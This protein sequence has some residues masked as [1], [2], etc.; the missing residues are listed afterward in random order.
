VDNNIIEFVRYP[1]E[2]EGSEGCFKRKP[3]CESSECGWHEYCLGGK[4]LLNCRPYV[5]IIYEGMQREDEDA[6]L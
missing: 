6:D 3:D 2:R 4:D 1:Q 5:A